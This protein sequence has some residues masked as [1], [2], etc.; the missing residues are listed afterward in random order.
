MK[1]GELYYS[2][3]LDRLDIKNKSANSIGGLHC[4]DLVKIL[5]EDVWRDA[6]IEYGDD[7]YLHP[8]FGENQIPRGLRVRY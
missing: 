8:L 4:G 6:R 7:W 1:Q 3:D 5:Y 2:P